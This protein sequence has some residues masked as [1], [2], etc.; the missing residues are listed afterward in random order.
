MSVLDSGLIILTT[1]TAVQ[2]AEAWINLT[3]TSAKKTG[4]ERM[5]ESF[6]WGVTPKWALR[7]IFRDKYSDTRAS[8]PFSFAA[9]LEPGLG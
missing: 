5:I 2:L 8:P 6:P 1:Y 4:V 7:A 9:G 3:P